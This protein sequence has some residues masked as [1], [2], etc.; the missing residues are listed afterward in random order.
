M[1]DIYSHDDDAIVGIQP[2]LSEGMDERQD[3]YV[4]V[5]DN[6][7]LA[8]G[9]YFRLFGG[10]K[11]EAVKT[12]TLLLRAGERFF[13]WTRSTDG[14]WR[15]YWDLEH[16]AVDVPGNHF[17]MMEEHAPTTAQAVEGWLDTTG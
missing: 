7:L 4:P 12:P 3:T 6:R 5:D 15:S 17:T 1:I 14:D 11:P 10:W 9:A 13:D 8:M 16:T 2:G